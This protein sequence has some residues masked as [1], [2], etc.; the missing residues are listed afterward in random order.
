MQKY[1]KYNS[2]YIKSE[3]HQT[4]SDG[5]NIFER[6][7]VTIGSQLHFGSD[8]VPYYNNGN[9]IFTTTTLPFYQKKYKNG[10]VVGEWDYTNVANSNGSVNNVDIDEHT[11]DIRTFA[12]YGS[13][14]ELVRSSIENIINNFPGRI[15]TINDDIF[16]KTSVKDYLEPN[17]VGEYTNKLI[18]GLSRVNN[19]FG[20]LFLKRGNFQG[21]TPSFKKLYNAWRDSEISVD[22][23]KTFGE[24]NSYEVVT[25]KLYELKTVGKQ[26]KKELLTTFNVTKED[27]DKQTKFVLEYDENNRLF[28]E[29]NGEKLGWQTLYFNPITYKGI[30]GLPNVK[31]KE[32][33]CSN[34]GVVKFIFIDGQT[35][36]VANV[37]VSNFTIRVF[38]EV[39]FVTEHYNYQYLTDEEYLNDGYKDRGWIQSLCEFSDWF[40]YAE[41]FNHLDSIR[42]KEMIS[43]SD[44]N[45]PIYRI[46]INDTI[47]FECYIRNGEEVF[48][49]F[50][51]EEII[52]RPSKEVI[53]SYFQNLRGFE[54]CLLNRNSKPLYSNRFL[55]PVGDMDEY[56]LQKRTYTWPSNDYCIDVTSTSY[57][58]FINK[59][60]DTAQKFDELFTDNIWRKM[61]HE[62]IKNYDW[63]SSSDFV[64]DEGKF[65]AN[66]MHNVVN[67]LGRVFDDIKKSIDKVKYNNRITYN[68][69]RNLPNSLLSD[70][71]DLGG[72]DVH[73]TIPLFNG[74]NMSDTKL[75]QGFL[76]NFVV[77][78]RK[79]YSS[80]NL[81]NIDFAKVDVEF[82][83]RLLLSSKYIFQSKGTIESIEMMMGLFG[84][85][86][87][88][89]RIE[90]EYY[91]FKPID[92][93]SRFDDMDSIGE[94]IVRINKNKTEELLY[95]DVLSGLPLKMIAVQDEKDD[96][97][98]TN[99][100][101]LIPYYDQ[102][103][104]YDGG[105]Y[106]QSK[107]G[108][109]E[110]TISYLR[111]VQNIGELL[112]LNAH[113]VN[114]GS[115]YYV[116]NISDIWNYTNDEYDYFSNFFVLV[117]ENSPNSFYSWE[118]ID[119]SGKSYSD[120]A[121]DEKAKY[122]KY[123]KNANYLN[124]I[125]PNNLG[126]N[127]HIGY[128]KYDNGQEFIEY[129]KK[130]FKYSIDKNKLFDDN[131]SD[132]K[133]IMFE[134]PMRVP[135]T[136]SNDKVTIWGYGGA[137]DTKETTVKYNDLT[138]T[139][140]AYKRDKIILKTTQETHVNS[141]VVRLK[142]F[143]DNDFYKEYFHNVIVKYLMQIV[144][145][146]T[147][148]ILEGF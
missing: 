93:N 12:Y 11:E 23:G 14:F 90:E 133:E 10:T 83:K 49:T 45:Y 43:G 31:L 113:T 77:D 119:M 66:R 82:M 64:E 144:P 48:Y 55:T 134:A 5:T 100:N 125:I 60:T 145:S 32:I 19:E 69:D 22:G 135:C 91:I 99:K 79:W 95:N 78:G 4:L 142:N 128:G 71:L 27:I 89:Y 92:Y 75:T 61:T 123:V 121:T 116:N 1:I 53:N 140:R 67:I 117:D 46:K 63:N 130:P 44:M 59:L 9:F 94:A 105:L 108:W 40:I 42:H 88:S 16:Y 137:V 62:T 107:G 120:L 114:E 29:I 76:D 146:T 148:M 51:T 25:S 87:N 68:S 39:G 17:E 138:L 20:F 84:C 13:C 102:S 73:T 96:K 109:C 35:K 36:D 98:I 110:E 136:S 8:K 143:F 85:D 38:Q 34:G 122:E 21:K 129:M 124:G 147:I 15:T 3:K 106:F 101:Y 33:L 47:T 80:S 54:K 30:E 6:D 111:V 118:M 26:S 41:Q 127:P 52:I 28:F 132:A 126:N 112:Q 57:I 24:I 7:W 141:K 97:V 115:I 70:K 56:E 50:N 2:N 72:W 65:G 18:K 104:Y 74:K 58:D 81:D 103:R 86:E 139:H 131:L 37:G